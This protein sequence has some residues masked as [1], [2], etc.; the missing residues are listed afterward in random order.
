[1]SYSVTINVTDTL[2]RKLRQAASLFRQPEETIILD[3][4]RHALPPLLEDIPPEYQHDV[5]PL[6]AMNDQELLQESQRKFSHE[7]WQTYESL[8]ER[9]K[10]GHLSP[11]EDDTLRGFRREADIL[12]LRRSYA[13]VLLKRR[14]YQL[15]SL[16]RD[17]QG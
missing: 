5:F 12:T 16:R 11:D 10:R 9:K 4:L 2:W 1:M 15:P 8:L 7:R 13:A 17:S 14:G 6:L 3:S